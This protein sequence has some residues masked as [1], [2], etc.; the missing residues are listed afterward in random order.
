MKPS[1]SSLGFTLLEILVAMPIAFMLIWAVISLGTDMARKTGLFGDEM[2]LRNNFNAT[3]DFLM[4]EVQSTAALVPSEKLIIAGTT[5]YPGLIGIDN[6]T[7]SVIAP[8][9]CLTASDADGEK[10]SIVR[11]TSISRQHAA[12]RVLR[13]WNEL[14]I[15]DSTKRL[16]LSHHLNS[17]GSPQYP[18]QV[19][20]TT[21]KLVPEIYLIDAD[22]VAYRRYRPTN[23]TQ[24]KNTNLDPYDDLP[25]TDASGNPKSFEYTE[26]DLLMPQDYYKNNHTTS[27]L[28]F[29]TGSIAYVANTKR[30]CVNPA[31]KLVEINEVTGN[32]KELLDPTPY[33][34]EISRFQVTY[35]SSSTSSPIDRAA[36]SAY[37]TDLIQQRCLNFL[38]FRMDLTSKVNPAMT[39]TYERLALIRNFN[40]RRSAQ[41]L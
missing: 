29:I 7:N 9:E 20:G 11:H 17:T 25:K 19:E 10:F 1:K 16:R 3:M 23:L 38:N 26:V 31:K 22:L 40:N 15:G 8:P 32:V 39:L 14:N 4:A 33:K 41:C 34:F 13:S 12:E 27:N 35:Y 5:E 21:V 24:H 30:I 6:I 36:F 28:N 37:P 2:L 18:F